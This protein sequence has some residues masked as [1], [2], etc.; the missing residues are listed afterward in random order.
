MA[1]LAEKILRK[2]EKVAGKAFDKL[3]LQKFT[4][5]SLEEQVAAVKRMMRFSTPHNVRRDLL[6]GLPGDIQKLVDKGMEQSE[7]KEHY[8]GCEPF[9]DL[10]CKTL[11]M[12]EATFDELLRNTLV[13][14]VAKP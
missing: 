9:R 7:I 5:M 14:Y 12:E 13:E 2:V 10:W 8:W 11:E 1:K 3:L 6:N 4:N